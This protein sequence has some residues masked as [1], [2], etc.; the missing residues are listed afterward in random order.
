MPSSAD[1]FAY[2][3]LALALLVVPAGFL[4][5]CVPLYRRHVGWPTYL[6]YLVLFGTVGGWCLVL[7]LPSFGSAATGILLLV[8]VAPLAC[9]LAAL[10]LHLRRPRRGILERLALWGSYL[11]AGLCAGF[12]IVGLLASRR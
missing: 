1:L 3:C 4:A 7:G 6:A 2:S 5:F 10:R 8:T 11:Y 12:W 9:L